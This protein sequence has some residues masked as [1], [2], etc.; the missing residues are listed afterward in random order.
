MLTSVRGL[1]VQGCRAGS[2]LG[3]RGATV[4]SWPGRA[5]SGNQH[6]PFPQIPATQHG[7]FWAAATASRGAP[8]SVP[9]PD[10]QDHVTF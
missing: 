3:E 7:Q 1:V 8:S 6:S 5:W 2:W 9:R 10:L 4:S